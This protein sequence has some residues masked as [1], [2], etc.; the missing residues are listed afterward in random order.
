MPVICS[1]L[2]F[3]GGAETYIGERKVFSGVL[4]KLPDH[5]KKNKTRSLCLTRQ[6]SAQNVSN[7]INDLKVRSE[8]IEIIVRKYIENALRHM[9]WQGFGEEI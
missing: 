8:T 3:S 4:D 6:T 2:G 1:Q 5:V 9:E 7:C